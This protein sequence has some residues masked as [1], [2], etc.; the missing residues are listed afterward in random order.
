MKRHFSAEREILKLVFAFHH[1]NYARYNTYQHVYL[2]DLLRK[3]KSV[4]KDVIS[5][6]Y[7]ASSSGESF[8]TIHGDLVTEHFN[9]ETKGTA[10]PFRSGYSTAIYAVNKWI[11]TSHIHSKMQTMLWKNLKVFTS[12]AHKETT[13]GNKRLHFEHVRSL[14]AKLKQNN[15]N[16]FRGGPA[17]NLTTGR[18]ID[19]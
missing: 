8:S 7:G 18:E 16:I 17:R 5:N 3:D 13:P 11:K 19:R 10:G 4:A 15:V 14:K 9:K 1:I 6:G 12:Q 2:N